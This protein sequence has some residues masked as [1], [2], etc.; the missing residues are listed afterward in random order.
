[1]EFGYFACIGGAG[2]ALL[3]PEPA[4]SVAELPG[5]LF[6]CRARWHRDRRRAAGL[7]RLCAIPPERGLALL[8]HYRIGAFIWNGRDD[9]ATVAEWPALL[10]KIRSKNIPIVTLGAGDAI[11]YGNNEIDMLSP[12]A[13]FDASAELNDTVLVELVKTAGFRALLTADIGFNVEDHLMAQGKTFAP[14]F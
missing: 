14:I 4:F 2:M 13:D 8:D 1:M 3:A 7:R 11:R 6:L 10:Q 9:A 5:P 12:D